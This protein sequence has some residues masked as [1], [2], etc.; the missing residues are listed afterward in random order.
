MW[1]NILTMAMETYFTMLKLTLS[2]NAVPT[3]WECFHTPRSFI[4]TAIPTR[5]NCKKGE[6]TV[7]GSSFG[8]MDLPMRES[9]SGI[10]SMGGV[11]SRLQED[12][13]KTK[14]LSVVK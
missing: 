3:T 10:K 12:S 9:T 4:V 1:R 11:R 13:S 5:E 2:I 6:S 7:E 14:S 8:K